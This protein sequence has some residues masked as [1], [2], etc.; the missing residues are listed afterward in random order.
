[1]GSGP[2]HSPSAMQL[3]DTIVSVVVRNEWPLEQLYTAIAPTVVVPNTLVPPT[4]GELG[5]PQLTTG[6]REAVIRDNVYTVNIMY[7]QYY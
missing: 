6:E 1:M 4:P 5:S 3:R 7:V 2:D